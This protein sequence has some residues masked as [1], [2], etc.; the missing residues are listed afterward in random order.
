MLAHMTEHFSSFFGESG[1]RVEQTF[2]IAQCGIDGARCTLLICVQ[3][4]VA[5][6]E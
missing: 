4:R 6:H 1:C 5:A 3:L 2:I